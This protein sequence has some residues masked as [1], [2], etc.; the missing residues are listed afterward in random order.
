MFKRLLASHTFRRRARWILTLLAVT[1]ILPLILFFHAAGS[2]SAA[3]PGGAAGELFGHPVPWETFQQEYETLR[4]A[5]QSQLG[6]VPLDLF[7]PML[8]QQAWDRLLIREDAR[9]HVRL[10]DAELAQFIQRQPAF[11]QHGRFDSLLYRRYVRAIGSTERTFEERLRD[12]LRAQRRIEAIRAEE[13]VT[14]DEVQAAYATAYERMRAA[15]VVVASDAFKPQM[16]R[17]LTDDHLRRYYD[18]RR[19]TFRVPAKRRLEYLGMSLSD[20]RDDHQLVG[21]EDLAAYYEEHPEEFTDEHGQR[22]PQPEVADAIRQR[23]RDVQAHKRLTELALDVEDDLTDGLRFEDVAAKR[24]LTIRTV[25]PTEPSAAD[26]PAGLS[27]AMV[28]AAFQEPLGHPTAVFSD[29]SGA[30]VLRPVEELPSRIPAFEELHDQLEAQAIAA[31]AREAAADRATHL[32]A[33]LAALLAQGM[34]VDDACRALSVTLMRP[35]PF[36]PRGPVASLGTVPSLTT[37]LFQLK[38]GELSE[39]LSIP[40]GYVIGLV[41]ERLP[42]DDT[43]F[44]KDKDAFHQTALEAKRQAHLAEWLTA[45]RQQARLKSYLEPTK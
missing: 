28:D 44:A 45:L 40:Q 36:T 35:T 12:D 31:L 20:A 39:A 29:P 3:G 1:L 38:P 13:S 43:Q 15:L 26:L 17:Q 22:R 14:D 23:L 8:R 10:R 21:E 37:A 34:S 16:Q 6:T 33:E 11:Q 2:R 18:V 27:R 9:R 4:K 19:E 32:Q 42:F 41:E 5:L 24:H 7:E 30:F 25:G